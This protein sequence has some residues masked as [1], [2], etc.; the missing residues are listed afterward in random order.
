QAGAQSLGGILGGEPTSVSEA[1]TSVF[2]ESALFDPLRTAATGRK[3]QINSDARYCF[4]RGVDPTSAPLGAE[5]GA[6]MILELC[7]GEASELVIAG[8]APEH[9]RIIALDPARTTSHGG[10]DLS[11]AEMVSILR[12]LG[13]TVD[14][15]RT[16][17]QVQP[18]SWRGDV[19]GWPDLVEE[20]L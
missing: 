3:L 1:T 5:I 13:F 15:S 9:R 11:T 7:G 18:P 19:E 14:D 2:I 20:I 10:L 16:P 6:R 17:W 8:S 12:R 4:E